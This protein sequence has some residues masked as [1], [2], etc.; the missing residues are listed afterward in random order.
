[1]VPSLHPS[2]YVQSELLQVVSLST[3]PARPERNGSA[4]HDHPDLVIGVTLAAAPDA[5]RSLP[6][7]AGELT[8]P[9]E[10]RPVRAGVSSFTGS[11]LSRYL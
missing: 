2:L 6:E 5:D 1:M 11:A 10:R 4:Q 7:V 9:R 3:L 8:R